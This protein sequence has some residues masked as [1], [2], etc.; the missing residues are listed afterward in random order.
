MIT[1]WFDGNHLKIQAVLACVSGE[2]NIKNIMLTLRAE[3][4]GK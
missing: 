1:K 2:G 3:C 4:G